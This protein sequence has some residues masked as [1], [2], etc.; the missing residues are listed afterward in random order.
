MCSLKNS[1][2]FTRSL[3]HVINASLTYMCAMHIYVWHDSNGH[4]HVQSNVLLMH[5]L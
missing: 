2:S 1:E 4:D 5:A 3:V